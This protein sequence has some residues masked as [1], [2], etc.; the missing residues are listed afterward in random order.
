MPGAAQRAAA[1]ALRVQMNLNGERGRYTPH[2]TAAEYD[3]CALRG[4]TPFRESANPTSHGGRIVRSTDFIF[5]ADQFLGW[6]G[7]WPEDGDTFLV[8]VPS[9]P[10]T[11]STRFRVTPFNGEPVYRLDPTGVQLRVHMQEVEAV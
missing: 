5:D 2:G 1:V 4:Q 10:N 9:A 6:C 11:F 3:L 7:R 8:F